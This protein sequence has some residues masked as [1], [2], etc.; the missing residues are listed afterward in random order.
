MKGENKAEISG[1]ANICA[2]VNQ[3]REKYAYIADSR[4]MERKCLQRMKFC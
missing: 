4:L 3:M 2:W 1:V